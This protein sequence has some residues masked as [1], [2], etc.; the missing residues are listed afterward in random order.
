MRCKRAECSVEFEAGRLRG[1]TQEYCS[2]RC[3][4]KAW[5][6]R[7]KSRGAGA[8]RGVA[9]ASAAFVGTVRGCCRILR[10]GSLRFRKRTKATSRAIAMLGLAVR[11]GGH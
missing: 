2:S 1:N 9:G 11:R 8:I 10:D 7:V 6:Q 5:K 3:R 4:W